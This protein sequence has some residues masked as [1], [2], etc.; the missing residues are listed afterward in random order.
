ME[1][2]VPWP[3][4]TSVETDLSNQRRYNNIFVLQWLMRDG[5]LVSLD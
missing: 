3:S 2:H 4:D 5:L 1:V